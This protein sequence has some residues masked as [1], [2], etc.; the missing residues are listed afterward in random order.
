VEVLNGILQPF[1][2]PGT[3]AQLAQSDNLASII[4]EGAHFGILLFSQPTIWIFGWDKKISSQ[5]GS[6]DR[7]SGSGSGNGSAKNTLVVFTSIGKV[8]TRDQSEHLR[9]VV[10][11]LLERV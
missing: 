10:D 5:A 9:V 3:E 2:K 8:I 6:K 1:I 11:A 7:R 4:L